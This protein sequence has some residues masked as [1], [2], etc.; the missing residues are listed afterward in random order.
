M[1]A[2]WRYVQFWSVLV[3]VAAVLCFVVISLN[4]VAA[5]P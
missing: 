5:A 4:N 1:K 3:F 2:F